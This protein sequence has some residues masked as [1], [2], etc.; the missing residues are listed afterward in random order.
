[1]NKSSGP[2]MQQAGR[3]NMEKTG[4]GIPMEFKGPAMHVPGH[5]GPIEDYK[6]NKEGEQVAVR[7]TATG[8]YYK[9]SEAGLA[10]SKKIGNKP[11]E[12]KGKFFSFDQSDA[13]PG[14]K[15]P[16]GEMLRANNQRELAKLKEQY[17]KDLRVHNQQEARRVDRGNIARGYTGS[18]N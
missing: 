8:S 17:Q 13:A 14:Y 6:V 5:D 3:G 9:P 4:R 7:D 16:S 1:M 2:Y 18:T 15:T 12:F 11:R 10:A